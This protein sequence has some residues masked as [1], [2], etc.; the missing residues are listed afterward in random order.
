M[1]VLDIGH[2]IW[3]EV[4]T[5]E[6]MREEYDSRVLDVLDDSII[7]DIPLHQR[8][9]VALQ[10]KQ[11]RSFWVGFRGRDG[12]LCKY[13]AHLLE[14]ETTPVLAWKITS[15]SVGNIS[16]EQRRE[17]ARVPVDLPARLDLLSVVN[18]RT[19]NVYV[20]DLSGGGMSVLLSKQQTL[21]PGEYVLIRFVIPTS[22]RPVEVKCFVIRIGPQNERGYAV[23]SLQ[24]LNISE[25]IRKRVIQYVYMRQRLMK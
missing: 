6:S 2:I 17:F 23:A 12:A 20:R 1:S 3:L 10:R 13:Q 18:P 25:P 4:Q 8:D 9:H 14:V 24:F 16:R 11:F 22:Q 19:Y 15:P 5:N 7:I 21:H